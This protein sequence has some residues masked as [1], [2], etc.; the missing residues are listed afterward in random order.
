VSNEYTEFHR[1]RMGSHLYP[2]E[3]LIRTMLGKYPKLT[4]SR[5]YEGKALL[6]LGF[7]DGRN[8][9][10]FRNLGVRI[11]GIESDPKVCA[12]VSERLKREADIES[13]LVPG[14][15]SA[16]P[17]A[18]GFFDF[19]VACR[20]IYY[21]SDGKT[22]PDSLREAARVLRPGG[23]LVA[24]LPDLENSVLANAEPLE[25]GHWRI[26]SDPFGLRNGTVF[27]AFDS[28]AD[29][30]RAFEPWFEEFSAGTFRDDWYGLR[31]T[32]F[33][34]VCRKPPA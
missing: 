6:D 11:F 1:K 31:V 24:S 5:D 32:G 19:V 16:I 10:L 22:F 17:F 20:S 7:G 3:F 4:M 26:T 2:T 27:R 14:T 29:I 28:P 15:N 8:L 25:D 13:T 9:P 34:V 33:A 21:V 12:M 18:D 30:E 23:C